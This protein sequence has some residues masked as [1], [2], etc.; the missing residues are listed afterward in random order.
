MFEDV[1]GQLYFGG[2]P[3]ILSISPSQRLD[4]ISQP[5]DI[6][7]TDNHYAAGKKYTASDDGQ[8][9]EYPSAGVTPCVPGAWSSRTD[10]VNGYGSFRRTNGWYGYG[11]G[12]HYYAQD[13]YKRQYLD[14]V[15][16]EV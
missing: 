10:S 8:Y 9:S 6:L 4:N 14:D 2:I 12:N 15:I 13:V 11:N 16:A 1:D 3:G 7:I 5:K